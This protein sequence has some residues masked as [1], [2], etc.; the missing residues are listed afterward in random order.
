[1]LLNIMPD[2]VTDIRKAICADGVVIFVRY[3]N[4]KT[5]E[6]TEYDPTYTDLSR[7]IA[8]S[9]QIGTVELIFLDEEYVDD[10]FL[11]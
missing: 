10:I 1:M 7:A 3:R 2:I 11:L 4:I 8:H 5:G 6:V 9:N